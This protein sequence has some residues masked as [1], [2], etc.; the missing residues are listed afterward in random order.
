[1]TQ[2]GSIVFR[3]RR[4]IMP[5][6]ERAASVYV[7]GGVIEAVAPLD[8][9]RPA[10]HVIDVGDAVLM[11]GLIDT[12]VHIDEPGRADWE[13][14]E[15]ATLAAAA[16]GFTTLVD[17]PLNCV[18]STTT[19]AALEAKRR[20]ANGKCHV[21]VAFWGGFVPG[22]IDDLAALAAAGVA[23]FKCFL[24]P[25]ATPEFEY[26][27]EPD[28][29]R[30]LPIVARLGVPLL[31]HAELP[32]P[33]MEAVPPANAD[34]R[35]YATYESSRPAEAETEAVGL[36]IR[37]AR[38]T[39]A[40]VHVVH[41]SAAAVIPLL[42][43]ARAEGVAITAETCPH[44]LHFAAEDVPD[45]ATAYKCAPPIRGAANRDLLWAA[46]AEGVIDMIV[47]DHSPC[48]PELKRAD[49]DFLRAWGGISSLQLGLSVVW[50]EAGRRGF[51]LAEVT[52][53]MCA[54]PA[55]LARLGQRK[56]AIAPGL[57]ADLIAFNPEQRWTVHPAELHHRH[58]ITPYAGAVLDGLVQS[59]WLRGERIWSR[60]GDTLAAHSETSRRG[61]PLAH[62]P[63][64]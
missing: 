20:A 30:G 21:D 47:S 31:A 49:G 24:V 34:P 1:V 39:R 6:G 42:R 13:G 51:T 11:P 16:G 55:R 17:M 54:A 8:D 43:A 59:T 41:V 53:W 36:L 62:S 5:D 57:D 25:T 27:R 14:F 3:A 52:R 50:T 56:G 46:L 35:R 4:A 19:V 63:S 2:H 33:I 60:S 15:S 29:E 58:A 18:P 40:H 45:G 22:S 10:D 61:L 9:P 23:G 44:Y 26:V 48:P 7:R 38:E 12:H 37:L 28:L 64:P 32:G